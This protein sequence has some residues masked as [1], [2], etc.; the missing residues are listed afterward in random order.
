MTVREVFEAARE[1]AIEMRTISE[2]AESRREA[3]GV[4]GHDMGTHS[5]SGILD[6]MRK[7]LELIMWE[8]QQVSSSGLEQLVD[9]ANELVV[10]MSTFEPPVCVEIISKYYLMGESWGS[11]VRGNRRMGLGP[12][13]ERLPVLAGKDVET[14]IAIVERLADAAIAD[15]E[16]MGIPHLRRL[17]AGLE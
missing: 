4:Q 6:P 1:A 15:C 14:Q 9:D 10:G 16:Q 2:Q 12:I 8:E 3:I 11:I 5:K 13:S 7:V 17:A